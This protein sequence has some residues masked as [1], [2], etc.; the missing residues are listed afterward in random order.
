MKRFRSR[1]LPAL[2][3]GCVLLALAACQPAP[4]VAG[5]DGGLVPAP[6]STGDPPLIPHDVDAAD[7]GVACLECHR[8]GEGGAPRTPEWHAGLV[9]CRECHIRIDEEREPFEPHY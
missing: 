4:R 7:S 9:D 8:T 5:G 3:A 1:L 6:G 2:L